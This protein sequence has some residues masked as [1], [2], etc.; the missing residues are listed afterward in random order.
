MSEKWSEYLVGAAYV[1]LAIVLVCAG[2]ILYHYVW[3]NDM[4]DTGAYF[5][6]VITTAT[7]GGV[8]FLLSKQ[9]P[10]ANIQ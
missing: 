5:V 3:L 9:N 4:N 2:V 1:N 8:A 7:F 6:G 10:A